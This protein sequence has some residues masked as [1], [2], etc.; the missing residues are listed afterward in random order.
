LPTGKIEDGVNWKGIEFY[1]G[2]VDELIRAGIEPHLCL[3]HWDLPQNLYDQYK[4][5]LSA[6]V[7]R[8]F[9]NYA[10]L[11][12]DQFHGKVRNFYTFNEPLTFTVQ[13]YGSGVHAPGTSSWKKT[14]NSWK[15]PY[16]AAHHVLLAHAHAAQVYKDKYLTKYPDSMLSIVLNSDFFFPLSKSEED[17]AA[18]D[19]AVIW[20]F[21][22]FADPL[23]FG[24]YP[25]EMLAAAKEN[26]T[27]FTEEESKLLKGS[28]FNAEGK[29]TLGVN[30]YSS[31]FV[32]SAQ[33]ESPSTFSWGGEI[34][35]NTLVTRFKGSKIIGV[36]ADSIWLNVVPKGFRGLLNWLNNRY[37][38]MGVSYVITENGVDCPSESFLNDES[39]VLNDYFRVNYHEQY[40]KNL[41]FA[42]SE[43]NIDVRG[44]FVWS[45]L[46]NY[47]WSDGYGKRFGI[48]YVNYD[49]GNFTRTP[50]KSYYWYKY[51]VHHNS[52]PSDSEV[53][54]QSLIK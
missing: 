37:Q 23:I 26:M 13:G 9:R 40:L 10:E 4:G 41:L 32:Q 27:S 52:F 43:D 54:H 7:V 47:E 48:V 21:A 33:G 17:L 31:N 2:L 38:S 12:F 6:N 28:L 49:D 1:K 22:W 15:D 14:G 24:Q 3:Y 18:V 29:I 35:Q 46:D 5:W 34:N 42:I 50:K 51:L 20:S 25:K 44:Y 16:T 8:D 30:H 39:D 19:R 36:K 45:L 11:I 53:V